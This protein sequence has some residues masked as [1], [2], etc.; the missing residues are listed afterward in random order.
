MLI[1]ID[2]DNSLVPS[3]TLWEE[4]MFNE[5][6]IDLKGEHFNES[7]YSDDKYLDW[8]KNPNLYDSMT[9]YPEAVKYVNKLSEDGHKIWIVT[10]CFDEHIDS[11]MRFCDKYFNIDRFL[12]TS[13]KKADSLDGVLN[14]MIDDRSVILEEFKITKCFQL[15]TT[16]EE[17]GK[18]E[19]LS[20]EQIYERIRKPKE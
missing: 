12:N 8:W 14:L 18:F 9:P 11:K 13:F 5:F 4:W 6:G 20:W 19:L 10:K 7:K 1:G 16:V 3:C 2:F 15:N 17:P